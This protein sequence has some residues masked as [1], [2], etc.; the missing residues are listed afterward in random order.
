M[1]K[2]TDFGLIL[3]HLALLSLSLDWLHH[4]RNLFNKTELRFQ[5]THKFSTISLRYHLQGII[6]ILH[7]LHCIVFSRE[8]MLKD[9]EMKLMHGL[10]SFF[11][12]LPN[13][14]RL[15]SLTITLLQEGKG[16]SFSFLFF[17]PYKEIQGLIDWVWC[18]QQDIYS[19]K[20]NSP[21]I[22]QN[23]CCRK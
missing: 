12:W 18:K 5:T 10:F 14:P 15:W 1:A 9:Q 17:S 13:E 22:Q 16:G 6:K 2:L 4:A 23:I 11:F 7:P 3:W 21:S 8:R 20:E 19:R